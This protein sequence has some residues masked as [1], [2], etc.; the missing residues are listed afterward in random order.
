MTGAPLPIDEVLPALRAALSGAGRAVLQAPPGAGKTTRVPLAL[1]DE[2]WLAGGRIVMLEPRRLAA[3]AAAAFMARSRGESVGDT[4][5]YRV[6]MDSRVGPR[7]RVEV[8]TE[9]VL[10]RMLL[11]DAALDGV[12]LVIF[13]EF[14]ERSIHADLGL[15]LTL[16]TREVLRPELR[17]LV[18]SATLEATAVAATLGGAPIIASEGR[19]HPVETRYVERRQGISLEQAVASAVQRAVA[20]ERGDVLVFLPGAG[21]IR[22]TAA[23]L[24]ARPLG[25]GVRV[26]P[27]HGTLPQPVQDLAISPSPAGWRKVVLS[28]SIAETS[29]T[30]E[31]VRVV[32]D[33]GLERVP[34]FSP[35]TGMSGLQTVRVSLASAEQRRGRAGRL[36]PGVCVR[37]WAEHANAGLLPR[38]PPEILGADLAPLALDLAA[39]GVRDPVELAWLDPPP[40]AAMGQA[41][42]LLSSLGALDGEGRITAHGRRM[43]SLALHP[44]LAHMILVARDGSDRHGGLPSGLGA[45]ACDVAALLSERDILR[46][47]GGMPDAD[48][49]LRVEALRAGGGAPV[50][51]QAV[52]REAVRRVRAEAE[53]WR[54]RLKIP[55]SRDDSDV[56]RCGVVLALAYP[57]RVAQRRAGGDRLLMRN[58]RGATLVGSQSLTTQPFLTIAAVDDR[59]GGRRS[60]VDGGPGAGRVAADG[61]ILLA[62][63]LSRD[64]LEECFGDAIVRETLVEWRAAAAGQSGGEG[65]G[66]VAVEVERLGAL[67]LAERPARSVDPEL[68]TAALLAGIARDGL[69]VLPWSEESLRVRQRLAFLHRLDATWPDVSDGALTATLAEWLGPHLREVRKPRDLRAIDLAKILLALPRWDQRAALDMLAPTHIAVPS[70]SRIP[71]DYSDPA[72]PV[73]AVRI[74]EVFGLAETPRIAR[75]SVPL[76]LHLLSPSHR[77]VQVTRDLAGFWATTYFDVR[78]DLR[79]RY[80][81]H[82][83]PDDP[84]VAPATNRAKPRPR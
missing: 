80:P 72:A 32:I 54:R 62:A 17:V 78:K 83:W 35:R 61:R 12:G 18:M 74:Q 46:G 6:R 58:G 36:G 23:A 65:G 1:L 71:V 79:G 7:T 82:A 20:D 19:A 66:V 4:V 33:A 28:T 51:G 73:L 5:G 16:Q 39:A 9:G 76:T 22:R 47:D 63:P 50:A 24:D 8:V 48:L 14:H 10:T 67:V 2:R 25:A 56:E 68:V 29:L 77:P 15:A 30:I 3:R 11:D 70:G 84:M 13:D 64:E 26:V 52:D 44:R 41:R 37:L 53:H 57:E 81:R 60:D 34:R 69:Q 31:G 75:G 43:A 38:R 42:E 40:A 49:R 21:E 55:S 27:L 59:A 45:L